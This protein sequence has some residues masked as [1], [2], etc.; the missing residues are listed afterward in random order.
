MFL[1]SESVGLP[2]EAPKKF[3]N[4]PQTRHNYRISSTISYTHPEDERMSPKK[5]TF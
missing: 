4:I 2:F 3:T 1:V 5:G